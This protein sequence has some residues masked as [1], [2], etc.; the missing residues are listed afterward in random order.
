MGHDDG[1]DDGDGDGDSDGDDGV[2]RDA[3]AHSVG[4]NRTNRGDRIF[5]RFPI[6]S[7]NRLE[8]DFETLKSRTSRRTR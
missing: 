7:G 5:C 4:N 3:A 8:S 2:V 1:N 6:Q